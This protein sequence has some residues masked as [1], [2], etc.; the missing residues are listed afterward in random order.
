[1]RPGNE[2]Q[3]DERIVVLGRIGGA[4]GVAGWVKIQSYTD[5]PGNLLKYPVWLLR[6]TTQ[7]SWTA[8]RCIQGREVPQGL[9]AQLEGVTDRDQAAMMRGVEIGVRRSELPAL[10]SGEFYWDDLIGLDVRSLEGEQLGRIEEITATPAHPLL[11]IV[12]VR[13][14][15][16]EELLVPLVRERIKSVDL[17]KRCV[18]VDWQRDWLRNE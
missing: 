6:T 15:R 7:G 16:S 12:D 8:S 3:S 4:F 1:M 13:A 9:Q 10:P 11:R 17:A 14:G 18:T 5:P 2:R